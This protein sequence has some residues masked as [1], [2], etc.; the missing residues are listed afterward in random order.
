MEIE[1]DGKS[2]ICNEKKNEKL[3]GKI[4]NKNFLAV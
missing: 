3:D 2:T 4:L 1:M